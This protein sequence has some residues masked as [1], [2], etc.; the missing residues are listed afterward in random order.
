MDSTKFFGLGLRGLQD[1]PLWWR[2]NRYLDRWIALS[3]L[4]SDSE[5]YKIC[6]CGGEVT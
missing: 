5:I 4:D 6:R 3:S 2:G 1:L